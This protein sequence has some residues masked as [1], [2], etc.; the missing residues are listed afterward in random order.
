MISS[1]SKKLEKQNNND[2]LNG[3]KL[4]QKAILL[5]KKADTYYIRGQIE[6]SEAMYE[7]AK[8]LR[9]D[10]EKNNGGL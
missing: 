10:A 6:K 1:N 8:Q 4:I 5:H 9:E 7:L 2:S 3:E